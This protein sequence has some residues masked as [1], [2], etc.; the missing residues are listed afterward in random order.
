MKWSLQSVKVG[1]FG[2]ILVAELCGP[3]FY[4]VVRDGIVFAHLYFFEV[5]LG[6]HMRQFL[7]AYRE[8]SFSFITMIL[9]MKLFIIGYPCFIVLLLKF[10]ISANSFHLAVD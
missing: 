8:R 2:Y 1:P 5:C 7:L 3:E 6:D 10:S 9:S 4:E